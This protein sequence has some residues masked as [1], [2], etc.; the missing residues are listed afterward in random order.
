MRF[1]IGL[2][3]GLAVMLALPV[4]AQDFQKG[5]EAAQ[6]GDYPPEGKSGSAP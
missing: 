2:I 1:I 5:L 3:L 4:A 6:R